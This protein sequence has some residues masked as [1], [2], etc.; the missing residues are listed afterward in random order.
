MRGW[1]SG[2]F[3]TP[4]SCLNRDLD[5]KPLPPKSEGTF[6]AMYGNDPL[7]PIKQIDLENRGWIA[8][9]I[10]FE[11]LRDFFAAKDWCEDQIGEV[12]NGWINLNIHTF[13]IEDKNKAV[14][15]KLAHA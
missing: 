7:A 3:Q 9:D 8:V 2:V 10:A 13:M 4:A 11:S 15:F 12:G 5:A 6:G 1:W 14:L